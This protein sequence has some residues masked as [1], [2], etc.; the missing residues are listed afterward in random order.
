MHS[1]AGRE[2]GMDLRGVGGRE[3]NDQHTVQNA[4]RTTK[5]I[6]GNEW[7]IKITY[8]CCAENLKGSFL[9][10]RNV[11]EFLAKTESLNV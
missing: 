1:W 6:G 11:P 8:I 5:N 10:R 7:V 3:M 9:C 2:E 4:Q